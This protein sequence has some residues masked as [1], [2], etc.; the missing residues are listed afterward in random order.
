[1]QVFGNCDCSGEDEVSAS[2]EYCGAKEKEQAA[3]ERM[4]VIAVDFPR[5]A[6]LEPSADRPDVGDD[7]CE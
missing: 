3:E 1:M 5:P 4:Q 7:A 6:L 2:V